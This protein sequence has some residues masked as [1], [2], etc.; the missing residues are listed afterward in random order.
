MPS[1]NIN[2]D[3]RLTDTPVALLRD[4]PTAAQTSLSS[5]FAQLN[6][7]VEDILRKAERPSET[8]PLSKW[9]CFHRFPA[10]PCLRIA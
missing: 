1:T 4:T 5:A 6:T 10:T 9:R 2:K 7:D 3:A 8:C